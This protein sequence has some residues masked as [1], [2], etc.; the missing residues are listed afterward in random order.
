MSIPK[1]GGWDERASTP[2]NYSVVFSQ[3]RATKRRLKSDFN[4]HSIANELEIIAKQQ[5]QDDTIMRRK[6]SMSYFRCCF[7]P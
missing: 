6:K 4:R 7:W 2:T 5:H 1:F 3:A